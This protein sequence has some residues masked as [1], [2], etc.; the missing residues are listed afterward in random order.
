MFTGYLLVSDRDISG[1]STSYRGVYRQVPPFQE[2]PPGRHEVWRRFAD[3]TVGPPY[4]CFVS[5]MDVAIRARNDFLA[6]GENYSVIECRFGNESWLTS[7]AQENVAYGFDV[8]NSCLH[9][10]VFDGPAGWTS[11]LF[12]REPL[13]Q[14][15]LLPIWKLE[16]AYFR[17]RLNDKQLFSSFQDAQ[18]YLEVERSVA[19]IGSPPQCCP[20]MEE[21]SV[22]LVLPIS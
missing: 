9:S 20:I 8:C 18:F 19:S 22:C 17:K 6:F 12:E 1:D 10:I 4:D 5:K 16:Y 15:S 13:H 7:S 14:S 11:R 2:A 21:F 3:A